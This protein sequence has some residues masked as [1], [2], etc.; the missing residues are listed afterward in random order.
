MF[1]GT[2]VLPRQ[3]YPKLQSSR[4]VHVPEPPLL[5]ELLLLRLLLLELLLEA[6]PHG[7]CCTKD[8]RSWAAAE[9]KKSYAAISAQLTPSARVSL[10]VQPVHVVPTV[11]SAGSLMASSQILE[12]NSPS[13]ALQSI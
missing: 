5:L 6:P 10:S 11:Q 8:S 7:F 1:A 9:A 4:T 12:S 13:Q 2:H 3:A